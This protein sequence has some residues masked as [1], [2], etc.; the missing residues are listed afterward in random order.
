MLVD[1]IILSNG[2]SPD[3]VELTQRTIESCHNSEP[4]IKFNII[5]LEQQQSVVY[6]KCIT[7]HYDEEFNYNALMN[8]GLSITSNKYVALCNNDLIFSK[9]WA[10]NIIEQMDAHKLLSASPLCPNTQGRTFKGNSLVEFGYNNS[11]HLS[12][13]CIVLNRSILDI[14]GELRS[15][16]PFWFA[17][18]EYAEQLK[19]FGVRHALVRN[20]VVTHIRSTTLNTIAKQDDYTT[21]HIRRFIEMY[22]ENES[23]LHFKKHY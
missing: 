18:N 21:A 17:D 6:D 13:W 12:G 2:K 20:S 5:V 23:A 10:S 22:P 7:G 8:K 4:V 16:F 9:Y 3:L 19:E 15:N 14:I 11:Q 1:I